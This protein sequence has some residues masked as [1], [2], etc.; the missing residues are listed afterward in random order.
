MIRLIVLRLLE[1]TFRRW[2]LWLIPVVV[3]TAFAGVQFLTATPSYISR[4][5]V[6][7]NKKSLLA[8]LTSIREDG[9]SWVTPAQATVDEFKELMNTDAFIRSVVQLTDLEEQMGQG[10]EAA[11]ETLIEAR[12]GVWVQT[13]GKNL[14][15]VG[16]AHEQAKVA[17][18]LAAGTI[19]VYIQWKINTEREESTAALQFLE[20]LAAT[21][22]AD[23][24]A[25]ESELRAYLEA[26]PPPLRGDRPASEE[27]EIERLQR[28]LDMAVGRYTKSLDDLEAT[29]LAGAVAESKVRQTYLL[30]DAARLPHT[31]QSSKKSALMGAVIFV[32]VGVFLSGAGVVGA[33]ML[34]RSVRFPEDVRFALEL[35]V[36]TVIPAREQPRSSKR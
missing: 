8:S 6:Y 10:T 11:A 16:A 35:P 13:L 27:I 20:N 32:V 36:L 22:Q 34:D 4:A 24:E 30:L 17:Q 5:A 2:F 26:H 9:F 3:M 12:S 29:Q 28:A 19:E 31:P 18:Q 7:V 33:A 23:M 1:S 15:M 25:A 21:Y 14:I